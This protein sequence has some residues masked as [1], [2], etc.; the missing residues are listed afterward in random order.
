MSSADEIL[1]L[2]ASFA[3]VEVVYQLV[4]AFDGRPPPIVVVDRQESHGYLPLVQE[5]LCGVLDPEASKLRTRAFIESVPGARFV[6]GEVEAFDA[7]SKTVTLA[8]GSRLTGRFVVVALGSGFDAPA[9]IDG[10]QHVLAYKGEAAFDEALGALEGALDG[11]QEP[12][13]VVVVGGGISGCELAGELAA[14]SGQRP[15]GW[16]APR[17]R[18]V[19][20]ASALVEGLGARISAKAQRAL[21][22]QGVTVELSTRLSAVRDGEADVL[23]EGALHTVPAAVVLW[24]GGIQPASVLARLGLPQT[25]TGWLAV[26]P[27]LQCFVDASMTRPDIFACG[28]AV[29]ICGGEGQW[30]TMQRAIECIWQAQVV[31]SNLRTLHAEPAD[32]PEGVPPLR[33]HTLRE[34]FFYGLSLGARSLVVYRGFGLDVPGVNH[35]FRR[36]LMR[37][38]FARYS[39]LPG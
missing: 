32:Y 20:G 11:A 34:E 18:L 15:A 1:I 36:W 4:R 30:D 7:A 26:G 9:V 23:R 14:L 13:D 39:P 38:Y 27:T 35:R 31:A 29:R 16:A 24:A 3:G 12:V 22:R 21:E 2:G 6:R 25:R 37:Q 33:P 28:D 19:A 17:V 10:A 8:D 5:R